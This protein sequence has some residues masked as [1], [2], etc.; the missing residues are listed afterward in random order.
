MSYQPKDPAKKAAAS[1]AIPKSKMTSP[2]SRSNST[3]RK[4][5]SV[6]LSGQKFC[7]KPRNLPKS[8]STDNEQLSNISKNGPS[9]LP[10]NISCFKEVSSRLPT[11]T[12]N[13]AP[14][15]YH[16]PNHH[17]FPNTSHIHPVIDHRNIHRV[18]YTIE[19]KTN[20][21]NNTKGEAFSFR[22]N[23]SSP[24][25]TKTTPQQ[26]EPNTPSGLRRISDPGAHQRTPS[27][28]EDRYMPLYQVQKGLKKGEVIEV[29]IY[30]NFDGIVISFSHLF[31]KGFV[32]NQSATLRRQK[33]IG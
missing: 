11:Y 33:D 19:L 23:K 3:V 26:S 22:N 4:S 12:A 1:T 18:P 6:Q 14:P 2:T 7:S 30:A 21:T 16:S 8:Y 10:A 9:S 29:Y 32:K 17:K 5:P 24:S 13:G 15:S 28:S 20:V 27:K 31:Q 25:T